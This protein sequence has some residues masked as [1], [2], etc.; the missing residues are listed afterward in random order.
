MRVPSQHPQDKSHLIASALSLPAGTPTRKDAH[1]G[2]SPALY[3]ASGKRIR[4]RVCLMWRDP[5]TP[6]GRREEVIEFSRPD[7]LLDLLRR[8]STTPDRPLLSV[9]IQ[10][11]P[12]PKWEDVTTAFLVWRA[13]ERNRRHGG[14]AR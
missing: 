13:A 2:L 3:A 6:S 14:G 4:H 11:K 5:D 7:R 1:Q 12:I 9:R 10:A 8:I